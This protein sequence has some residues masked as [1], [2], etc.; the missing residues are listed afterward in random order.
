M[1]SAIDHPSTTSNLKLQAR[2]LSSPFSK[3]DD[4]LNEHQAKQMQR[5][6]NSTPICVQDNNMC[7]SRLKIFVSLV[8][9]NPKMKIQS[10]KN[11]F[12]SASSEDSH[13]IF[14]SM[15]IFALEEKSFAADHLGSPVLGLLASI[16]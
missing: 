11:Q 7:Q 1:H 10:A 2:V 4:L 16:L 6:K 8:Q 5:K 13:T 3:V 15:R 9:R 14:A 12:K